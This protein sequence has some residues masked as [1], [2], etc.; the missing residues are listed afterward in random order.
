[1]LLAGLT[2]VVAGTF[3]PWL[4]SG[5]VDR[6]SYE[7]VGLLRRL[8]RIHGIADPLASV[9]PLL[10]LVCAAAA[11]AYLFGLRP[12]GAG[13]AAVAAIAAAAGAGYALSRSAPF[14]TVRLLG[15]VVTVIGAALTGTT[16]TIAFS[17][18]YAR[19]KP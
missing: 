15:P 9:W 18:A 5:S 19:R 13:L 7:S 16:A 14:V 6:N 8:D 1:M 11:A 2:L 3:L 10:S 17:I 12:A 4:R